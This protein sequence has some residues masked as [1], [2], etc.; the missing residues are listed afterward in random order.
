MMN[1]VYFQ[2][3]TRRAEIGAN[4]YLL[5]IGGTRIVLDAGSHPREEG[6]ESIPRFETLEP[7]GI[8]AAILTHTHLDHAG[9]LPLLTRRFR[10]AP[11]YMTE[12]TG[13]LVRAMLH[14]SVNVMGYKRDE[15]E[16]E[17]YPLFTHR[18]VDRIAPDWEYRNLRKPFPIGTG[19]VTC[20]FFDAGH[21]PGS[22]GALFRHGDES[23]FYTGDVNFEDQ[24]LS[25]A[26]DFPV[27]EQVDTLIIE[28]TRGAYE[29]PKDFTRR[30]EMLRMAEHINEALERGGS[31]LIPVFALGKTQE[32][33]L[34]LETLL[35]EGIIPE[36]PIRIGGLSTKM[37]KLID[38]FASTTRRHFPDFKIIRDMGLEDNGGRRRGRKA[39]GSGDIR[40]K[41]GCIYALSSGMMTEKTVSNIFAR[42]FIH[43][44]K[45][46]LLFVGYAAEDTPARRILEAATGDLVALDEET[47]HIELNCDVAKFDFS[48]HSTRE[49]LLKYVGDLR[50]KRVLLVHGDE[51]AMAWMEAKIHENFPEMDVTIPEP[52]QRLAL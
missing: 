45:N 19:D 16:L 23:V 13:A 24:T 32:V 39:T 37:T 41:P 15:L 46:A 12:T 42:G 27:D 1:D 20:E 4:S 38:K 9:M 18:E 50:P 44:P 52:E 47:S 33:L 5:G 21:I 51:D 2:S 29:R 7:E 26:A 36:C 17:N 43:N 25:K 22:V 30:G 8:D 34:M 40:Y 6:D 11:V 49:D 14:N 28:S 10:D 31:V 48:G 3:L 35:Q